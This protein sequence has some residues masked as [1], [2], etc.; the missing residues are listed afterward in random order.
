MAN[1][2]EFVNGLIVKAPLHGAASAG[3]PGSTTLEE[4]CK[5]E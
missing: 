3:T 5:D 1:D 2:I 4:I